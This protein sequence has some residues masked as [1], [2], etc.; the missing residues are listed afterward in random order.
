MS[1]GVRDRLSKYD[2]GD[3]GEFVPVR[4]ED[5]QFAAQFGSDEACAEGDLFGD[6]PTEQL[7]SVVL[8]RALRVPEDLDVCLSKDG[9]RIVE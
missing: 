7:A 8:D 4:T 3:A 2:S 5:E 1:H 9:R 6:R